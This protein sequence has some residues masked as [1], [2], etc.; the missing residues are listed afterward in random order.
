LIGCGIVS[1][2]S[3]EGP[4]QGGVGGRA[5]EDVETI[6][7][8]GG[9]CAAEADHAG[10]HHGH[11]GFVLLADHEHVRAALAAERD[12]GGSLMATGSP[13][14]ATRG[15]RGRGT[16]RRGEQINKLAVLAQRRGGVA[17]ED[18]LDSRLRLRLVVSSRTL[19]RIRVALLIRQPGDLEGAVAST[20]PPCRCRSLRPGRVSSRAAELLSP[21]MSCES[22]SLV[23]SATR[24]A[25]WPMVLRGRPRAADGLRAEQD[26]DAEGTA[27]A[28]E[29]IESAPTHPAP[30]CRLR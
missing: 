4:D 16:R 8:L 18:D 22:A 11:G 23:C 21:R 3:L 15:A 5:I 10:H 29:A 2:T 20:S 1:L 13:S 30:A 7:W 25:I 28:D 17:F 19:A 24:T 6:A 12:S 27:L 14:Q 9:S 26:V